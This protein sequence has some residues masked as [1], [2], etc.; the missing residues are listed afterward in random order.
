MNNYFGQKEGDNSGIRTAIFGP[1]GWI[2]LHS[3]AQNYPWNPSQEQ[4]E[5]YYNF[6]RLT[7]NVLPCRYCR[8]SY[9]LFITQKG[10]KL[11]LQ[12]MKNRKSVVT[13]LY[14]IHNKVNKKL[15]VKD[16]PTLKEVWDKYES[17]RSVCHKTKQKNVK[18]CTVPL[19]GIRKKCVINFIDEP[20]PLK[21]KNKNKIKNKNKV[22]L[23]IMYTNFGKKTKPQKP[24]KPSGEPQAQ[25][26]DEA[27]P[28]ENVF[29]NE[30]L[31][32][33]MEMLNV[34]NKDDLKQIKKNFHKFSLMYHPDRP[35]GDSWMFNEVNNAY[36]LLIAYNQQKRINRFGRIRIDLSPAGIHNAMITLSI[37]DPN[38]L[39]TINE[40]WNYLRQ[41]Y[42]PGGILYNKNNYN[43]FHR[44]YL[45]LITNF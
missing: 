35:T 27:P 44:A 33:A 36:Q 21:E 19:N 42:G 3:I 37:N 31:S 18:G 29:T 4:M 6:F 26:S 16:H 41:R 2:F 10:T 38:D 24:P 22:K 32:N 8:E 30:T 28:P 43:T 23:K 39:E 11:T 5:D 1:A 17:F 12:T 40:R 7:G 45:I 13:W 34:T 15:G 14:R 9:Q 25:S 20:L